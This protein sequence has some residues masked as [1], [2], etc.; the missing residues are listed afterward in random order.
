LLPSN[1][2]TTNPYQMVVALGLETKD[3][4]GE[5]TEDDRAKDK[6]RRRNGP[7]FNMPYMEVGHGNKAEYVGYE[8]STTN[9]TQH[10]LLIGLCFKAF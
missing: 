2:M 10:F 8:K 6:K 9:S 3:T 4:I 5:N 1:D 7:N